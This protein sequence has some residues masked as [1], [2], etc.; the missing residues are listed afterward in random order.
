MNV[1]INKIG[2]KTTKPIKAI[3]EKNNDGFFCAIQGRPSDDNDNVIVV[4]KIAKDEIIAL[5]NT[6]K[7]QER[8]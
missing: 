6:I 8:I 2:E 7:E 5:Y 3:L 1:I 4:I